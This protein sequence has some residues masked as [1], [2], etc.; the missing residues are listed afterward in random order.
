MGLASVEGA[1]AWMQGAGAGWHNLLIGY[2]QAMEAGQSIEGLR[3][4]VSSAQGK[5]LCCLGSTVV[6]ANGQTGLL[7]EGQGSA[8]EDSHQQAI[9]SAIPD[10]LMRMTREG[11]CL[12]LGQGSDVVLWRDLDPRQ[13]ASIYDLLPYPLAKKRLHYT[14][15]ALATQ[16]RQIYRQDIEVAGQLC[17]EEVRVIPMNDGE[18]L[19]IVRDITAIAEAERKLEEQTNLFRQQAQRDRVLAEVTQHISQSLD[20][21]E[22]LNTA[23]TELRAM[24]QASRVMVY[25]FDG[26]EGGGRVIAEAVSQP[27]YSLRQVQVEDR[28]FAVS[29]P[30][31]QAYRQGRIHRVADVQS[32]GLSPCYRAM[33]TQLGVRANLGLPILQGAT[34]WGLLVCHQCDAPRSWSDLEVETLSQ[35]A[36]QLAIAIQKSELYEQVQQVNQELQHLATHDKLTGLANRRY[37]DDYLD[38]VWQRLTHE[39][40]PLSLV[41]LDIDHF[42][43]YNDTHGH[44]AGDDCIEQVAMAIRRSI[45]RPANLAARYGGEEFAIILPNTDLAGAVRAAE[46]VRQTIAQAHLPHGGI[47]NQPYV[48]VSLGIATTQPTALQSPHTLIDQADQALYQAKQQGRNRYIIAPGSA[49]T[50]LATHNGGH[51]SIAV[52]PPA[53]KGGH[54][55]QHNH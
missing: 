24:M 42:K 12:Y 23:V 26:S 31:V 36:N 21:Q 34:L 2:R 22:V 4:I 35:L 39:R 6:L 20:L 51:L 52:A 32:S 19:V 33:L 13:R 45:Q 50:A 48:T 15:Q 3:P 53:Q 1:A 16:T 41:L 5:P 47:P 54:E 38:Q 9:L 44:L 28:C 11:Q 7:L 18:V 27:T 10:L 40:T 30:A 37:F 14:Q 25:R 55:V 8:E 17:H 46:R 49:E 29:S 43:R